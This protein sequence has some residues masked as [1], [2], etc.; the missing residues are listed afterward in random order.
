MAK[1]PSTEELIEI[2]VANFLATPP[3]ERDLWLANFSTMFVEAQ[4]S[5]GIPDP[6]I[7]NHLE[8]WLKQIAARTEGNTG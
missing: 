8:W 3:I 5:R 1:E 7:K 4:K 2:A 6:L